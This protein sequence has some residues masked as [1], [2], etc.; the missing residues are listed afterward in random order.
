[1]RGIGF[2]LDVD[3]SNTQDKTLPFA[4]I[5][6]LY[7]TCANK[8]WLINFNISSINITAVAHGPM[9]LKHHKM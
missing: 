9:F 2:L 6:T 5:F 1:M 3:I 7:P 8:T 4:F